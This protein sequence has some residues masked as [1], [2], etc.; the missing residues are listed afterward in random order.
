[1]SASAAAPILAVRPIG[2]SSQQTA[3]L[4]PGF[5]YSCPMAETLPSLTLKGRLVDSPVTDTRWQVDRNSRFRSIITSSLRPIT[6]GPR[7]GIR[8]DLRWRSNR[9]GG[10]G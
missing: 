10:R 7:P 4:L 5:A 1:M 9:G 8:V 2:S 6:R 3:V